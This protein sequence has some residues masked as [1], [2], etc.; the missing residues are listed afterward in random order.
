MQHWTE[1]FSLLKRC[2]IKTV[3]GEISHFGNKALTLLHKK[4][5]DLW[6]LNFD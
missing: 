6:S 1:R 2:K 3:T 4:K 5:Y